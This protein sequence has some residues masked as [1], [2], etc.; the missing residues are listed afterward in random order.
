MQTGVLGPRPA[1]TVAIKSGRRLP[2]TG[3]QLSP[4]NVRRHGGT[5]A[6]GL[7]HTTKNFAISFSMRSY[8]MTAA[9]LKRAVVVL[10]LVPAPPA[11]EFFRQTI[12]RLARECD[13][14]SFEPHLT[15][16]VTVDSP[17]LPCHLDVPPIKLKTLGIFWS[18]TF[19]KTLFVR[20]PATVELE[21]LR[22]LLGQ[23]GQL[24][25]PHLSLLYKKMSAQ[26]QARC[27]TR[28]V[29]PF[30][31]ARFDTVQAV[32]CPNPTETRADVESWETI[33]STRLLGVS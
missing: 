3:A 27:A 17:D 9:N 1:I 28:I 33:A 18:V 8:E 30:S 25:D 21:A 20:M 16:G 32:R 26:E 14:P 10:W 5:V 13:A 29:L 11:R 23:K 24:P 19:S 6:A 4:E 31:I 2:A 12:R 15:L 7:A 22:A